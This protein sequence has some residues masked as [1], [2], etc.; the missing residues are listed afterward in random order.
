MT[1]KAA[2]T[3]GAHTLYCMTKYDSG[4]SDVFRLL[5][6]DSGICMASLDPELHLREANMEFVAQFDLRS[7]GSY[8][9]SFLALLHPTVR[10]RIG[11]EL[12]LLTSG[13][14]DHISGRV[15]AVRRDGALLF[16]DL[17]A[18]S[19]S[20]PDGCVDTILVLVSR[21]SRVGREQ[22]IVQRGLRLAPMDARILEGVAAGVPTAK[23]A[24][25]LHLSRGGVEYR[26]M[27]LLRVLKAV[28]R[29]EL[30]SKAHS[31]G[32]FSTESWPPTVLSE[33]VQA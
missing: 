24:T 25:A 6:E 30:V 7:Q 4:Y 27:A 8:G 31:M 3:P 32:L 20:K 23:L 14:R 21:V 10:K 9:R 28:N 18:V 17:S 33:Y 11:R 5:F 12:T 16:G 22:A 13:E 2:D 15:I 1:E 19:T 29:I 26:I